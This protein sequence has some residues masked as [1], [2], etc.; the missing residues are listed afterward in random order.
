M[1]IAVFFAGLR[2]GFDLDHIAAIT[3]ITSSQTDRRQAIRFGTVYAIG[4]AIV[5]ALLCGLAILAGQKIPPRFDD[6]M[7]RVIGATLVL[8]GIYVIYTLIRF[9]REAK[10]RSRWMLILS[11]LKRTVAWL[12][13]TPVRE[14]EI[15]HTHEHDLAGHHHAHEDL[16]HPDASPGAVKTRTHSH[17][18]SHVLPAP[19]DPF[20]EYGVATSLGIG[21]IHG[22][23]AETPSQVVLFTSAAGVTG[24]FGGLG[25]LISFVAGLFIGNSILVGVSAAGFGRG[26]KLPSIYLVL[27]SVTAI[28]SIGVGLSYLL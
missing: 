16:R 28:V 8:L 23:G 2:H 26:S 15:S 10:L 13:R 5:L 25:V 14:V 11:G 7:G 27:A 20:T 24:A 4:H 19:S 18:H 1:L 12:R 9:G 6:V 22:V 3:D 21:M 17:V